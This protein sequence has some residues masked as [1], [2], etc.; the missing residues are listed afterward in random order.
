MGTPCTEPQT[1]CHKGFA[2]H[3]ILKRPERA[4]GSPHFTQGEQRS[5]LP[6]RVPGG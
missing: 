4:G 5:L 3:P 6:D 2:P 1:A